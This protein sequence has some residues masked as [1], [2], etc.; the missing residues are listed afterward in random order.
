MKK[1]I[2]L[3]CLFSI[4]LISIGQKEDLSSI[5]S[6]KW[7]KSTIGPEKEFAVFHFRKTFDLDTIPENL[8][9]NTSGDNRYRL[10][11][12]DKYVCQGPLTGDLRHWNYET[13]DIKPFLCRGK[14]VISVTV[15]NYG[16]HPP[17]AR[18][19]VQTGFLL[20]ADDKKF[21]FLNTNQTWKAVYD[22]AYSANI[23][24]K[25]QINGYY[26]GGSREIVDG[27]KYIWDFS[28]TDLDDTLWDNAV[29]IEN[30]FAKSCIWASRWKLTP[31]KLP[32]ERLTVQRF[33]SVRMAD[34]LSIPVSFPKSKADVYIPSNSKVR[35]VLDQGMETTAYPVL[36]ISDGKNASIKMTY[37]EAAYIGNPQ[38]QNKGNRND[39]E[40]KTFFGYYDK[41]ISDG[42]Q[43]RKYSPLWWRA[44]RYV[45]LDIETQSSPLVINDLHSVLSTYPFDQKSKF[46]ITG[47]IDKVMIDSIF[48]IGIRTIQ[49]CSHETYVDCPYYEESQFEGDT[50]VE[51]LASYYNFGDARLAE[52]AIEQFA[53]S[54]NDEGFLSA[55]YPTNSLYY[56]PNFSIY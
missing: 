41:Y 7:I 51:M 17:D 25:S 40:G 30:A 47:E 21:S 24:D 12:N 55:R 44:F 54:I 56:I 36:E 18:L 35:L 31:R 29:V 20:N 52:N 49:L 45:V 9:I 6:A 32:T 16:S 39:V 37:C 48:N 50:R 43:N 10:Y 8:V 1:Y 15:L 28:N 4:S 53:W 34:K 2:L 38:E 46:S 13:T 26:G 5:W 42:G 33:Q 14:N 22:R 11:V 23:I 27:N 19:S 3:F